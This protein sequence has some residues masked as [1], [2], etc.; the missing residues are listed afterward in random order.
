MSMQRPIARLAALLVIGAGLV[1]GSGV[2]AHAC[3]CVQRATVANAKQ[4]DAVFVG[5]VG[6]LAPGLRYTNQVEVSAFFKGDVPAAVTV[7]TGQEATGGVA[8]SCNY[9]LTP[10]EEL[11]FFAH[12]AGDAYS[13]HLCDFSAPASDR[14]LER[15]EKITGPAIAPPSP[16]PDEEPRVKESDQAGQA[17]QAARADAA[18]SADGTNGGLLWGIGLLVAVGVV[19][20]WALARRAR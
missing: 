3:S 1:L 15:I 19:A 4:A 6:D 13:T 11:L 8:S 2:S 16:S 7:N 18:A 10:G 14:L 17:G 5:T 20:V 12:G 9:Q